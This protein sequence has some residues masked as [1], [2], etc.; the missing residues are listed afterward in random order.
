[1][2]DFSEYMNKPVGE[3]VRVLLPPGHYFGRIKGHEPV[4]SSTNKPML[5]TQFTLD[6][7]ADDVDQSLLPPQGVANKQLTVNYLMA[8][9]FGQ[10]AIGDMIRATGIEIDPAQGWGQYLPA[11]VNQPVKLYVTQRP[12]N[13]E[14]PDG[15]KMEDVQKVLPVN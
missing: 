10:A 7:A 14:E 4:E 9:D 15:E 3:M 2:P 5:K 11:T 6:S 8:E 13:K 12:R 1:M